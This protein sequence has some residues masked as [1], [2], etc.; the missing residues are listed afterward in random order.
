[1]KVQETVPWLD[2]ARLICSTAVAPARNDKEPYNYKHPGET[3]SELA[4]Q[5]HC[6]VPQ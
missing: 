6:Y 1:M 2:V 3:A 5:I 4:N